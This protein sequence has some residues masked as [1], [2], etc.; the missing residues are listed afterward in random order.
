MIDPE[1]YYD[2][3]LAKPVV[4]MGRQ[5]SPM[6]RVI[7]KGSAWHAFNDSVISAVKLAPGAERQL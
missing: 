1:A 2:I 5:H 3:K 6:H 4:Y 7:I